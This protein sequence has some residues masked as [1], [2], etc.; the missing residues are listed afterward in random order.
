MIWSRE[1]KDKLEKHLRQKLETFDES[2]MGYW[3]VIA[4]LKNGMKYGNV[5]I[6]DNF[7]FGFPDLVPFSLC[8]ITEIER[9][10]HRGAKKSGTPI[11]IDNTSING[12]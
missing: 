2:G 10:G 5:C 8:D 9:C 3:I 7:Q 4:T 12:K 6:S 11:K 1:V